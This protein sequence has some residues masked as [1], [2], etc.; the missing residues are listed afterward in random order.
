MDALDA[1]PPPNSRMSRVFSYWVT[2]ENKN[3]KN[4]WSGHHTIFSFSFI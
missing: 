3:L 4:I 2:F 1:A